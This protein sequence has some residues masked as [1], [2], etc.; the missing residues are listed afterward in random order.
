[1]KILHLSA[2]NFLKLVAVEI[3][4]D[5]NLVKITGKNAQGKTSVLNAIWAAFAGKEVCPS[6]PI[7]RGEERATI[8]LDLGELIVTRTFKRAEG[9]DYT[10]AI[11]VEN[12]EGARYPSPQKMLDALL[13]ALAFDPLAFARMKPK[14][15]YEQLRSF[16]PDVDFEA[17][18]RQNKGDRERRT[19]VN[20]LMDQELA[21]AQAILVAEG[22]KEELLDEQAIVAE[23]AQAGTTNADIAVRRSNRERTQ[24]IVRECRVQAAQTAEAILTAASRLVDQR[25]REVKALRAHIEALEA[26]ISTANDNCDRAIASETE[27]LKGE[28]RELLTRADDLERHLQEAP[29]LPAEVDIEAIQ[30][31]ITAARAANAEVR[32]LLDRKRHWQAYESL[33]AKAQAYT[34]AMNQRDAE[35]RAKI[36]AA[37]M[38]VE[39]IEFGDEIVLLAGVPFEQASDAEQLRASV[40]IAMS[41]NPKLRVLRVRDGS[42]L[43]SNSMEILRRMCDEKDFQCWIEVVSDGG[44]MGFIIEDGSVKEHTDAAATG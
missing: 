36:A 40:A 21:A 7:R 41:L 4:P 12:A 15:Q 8:R 43:D 11:T 14:A 1:M 24:E 37:K 39:G 23:L 2:N 10:T 38:P 35:K 18:D 31:R 32:K 25:D 9:N 13:G 34:D 6:V 33:K 29:P 20:R 3:T 27:R 28:E 19:E 16:V 42:L 5:S 30:Q 17:I 44:P 22:T 26:Q